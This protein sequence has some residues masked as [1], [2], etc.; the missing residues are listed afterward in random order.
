MGACKWDLHS[1]TLTPPHPNNPLISNTLSSQYNYAIAFS[2]FFCPWF[3]CEG[4][5]G[6]ASCGILKE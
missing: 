5:A 6:G 2:V 1:Y 3:G 4:P